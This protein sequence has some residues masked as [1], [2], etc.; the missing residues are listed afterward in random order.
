M[1]RSLKVCR[2]VL[3]SLA[4]GI[5]LGLNL[6]GQDLDRIAGRYETLD[7][8]PQRQFSNDGSSR[9]VGEYREQRQFELDMDGTAIFRWMS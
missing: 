2:N 4:V 8:F 6:H 5:G 3:A 9:V 1:A 7:V